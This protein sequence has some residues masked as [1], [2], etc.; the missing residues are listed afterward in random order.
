MEHL[1]GTV[2]S[3]STNAETLPNAHPHPPRGAPYE[4]FPEGTD[5][6]SSLAPALQRVNRKHIENM[7]RLSLGS[8]A[9]NV[10]ETLLPASR[11]GRA[12]TRIVSVGPASYTGI[13]VVSRNQ[14]R[15]Q[16]RARQREVRRLRAQE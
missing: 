6:P 1:L 11:E 4:E 16:R 3:H 7:K 8:P 13:G 15:A 12:P 9:G 10:R 14:K 2:R 5:P